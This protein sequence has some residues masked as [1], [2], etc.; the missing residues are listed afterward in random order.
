MAEVRETQQ[1]PETKELKLDASD[2]KTSICEFTDTD[3]PEFPKDAFLVLQPTTFRLAQESTEPWLIGN[4]FIE[5]LN[6]HDIDATLLK[7]R[8]SKF[9]VSANIFLEGKMVRVKARIYRDDGVYLF[10][11]QQNT[12]CPVIFNKVYRKVL[13]FFGRQYKILLKSRPNSDMAECESMFPPF[14]LSTTP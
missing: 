12:G 10:E 2:T 1:N 13:S 11:L 6:S 8:P 4:S 5:F 14:S 9:S 3:V 7:V